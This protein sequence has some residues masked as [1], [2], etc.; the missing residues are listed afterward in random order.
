MR[1]IASVRSTVTF[2]DVFSTAKDKQKQTNRK[3][4]V[5]HYPF[6]WFGLLKHFTVDKKLAEMEGTLQE[7]G[8]L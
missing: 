6:N 1:I 8:R 7:C 4:K 3:Y 5:S 2:V